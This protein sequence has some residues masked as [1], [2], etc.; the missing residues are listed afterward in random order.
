MP[1]TTTQV[2]VPDEVVSPED[3]L[4]PWSSLLFVE[5]ELG[6]YLLVLCLGLILAQR[7]KRRARSA[8]ASFDPAVPLTPGERVL[9]GK[10]EHAANEELAVRVE[11][12]Q[13]GT[14]GESSGTW[15][16]SWKE[17]YRRV[18][19]HPFYLRHA[20]GQR[21]RVEPSEDVTLVDEMDGVIRVNLARRVRFA[22]LTPG[23]E[24]F[25][26]GQLE[27]STD[28]EA[29]GYRGGGSAL[30]LRPRRD[31][32]L[33]LSS[34]PL[35][36]R[37]RRR[38]RHH[39][40]FAV[41]AALLLVG[42]NLFVVSYFASLAAGVPGRARITDLKHIDNSDSDGESHTYRVWLDLQT[43]RRAAFTDDVSASLFKRLRVGMELPAR[44]TPTL[45]IGSTR[46]GAGATYH[47]GLL[48]PLL[49]PVFVLGVVYLLMGAGPLT[50]HEGQ[51]LNDSESGRLAD[52]VPRPPGIDDCAEAG[53]DVEEPGGTAGP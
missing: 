45:V 7:W 18:K 33:L 28:P 30:V 40:G 53:E 35:G 1:Q 5:L 15:S 29:G 47:G 25:A 2:T 37:F 41:A 34:E 8:D 4:G 38:Q 31:G 9:H 44:H 27:Q 52:S 3:H 14:E 13:D 48:L 10:V 49:L 42:A 11:V 24:I 16:T 51:E 17:A 36:E 39:R 26:H 21:I 50:W 32:Q 43:P 20:S 6:A 19:V 22:E 46:V 23:E 12:Y